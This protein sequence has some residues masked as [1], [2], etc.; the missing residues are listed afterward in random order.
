[1][2]K[3]IFLFALFTSGLKKYNGQYVK[4]KMKF[5]LNVDDST[6]HISPQRR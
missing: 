6:I 4:I 5:R 2:P 1:M 3:N